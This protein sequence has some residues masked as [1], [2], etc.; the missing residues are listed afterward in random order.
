MVR[1]ESKEWWEASVLLKNRTCWVK[2]CY[3]EDRTSQHLKFK[4]IAKLTFICH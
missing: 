3:V 2:V 4:Q 1:E